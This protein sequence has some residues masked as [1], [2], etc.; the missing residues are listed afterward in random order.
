[1]KGRADGLESDG[2]RRG[3]QPAAAGAVDEQLGIL[4]DFGIRVECSLQHLPRHVLGLRG[5]ITGPVLNRARN[6]WPSVKW[7]Q[8]VR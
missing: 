8:Q 5:S 3:A 1:M 6:L 2:A 4:C 7:R